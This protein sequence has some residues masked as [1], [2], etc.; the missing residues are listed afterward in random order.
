M[1]GKWWNYINTR[2]FVVKMWFSFAFYSFQA[3]ACFYFF[4][5]FFFFFFMWTIFLLNLLQC[6]FCCFMF[7]C[8][9][10]EACGILAPQ[11][12]IEPS[13]ASPDRETEQGWRAP[14]DTLRLLLKWVFAPP[15]P[16]GCLRMG[17]GPM[18]NVMEIGRQ[19]RTGG[20]M[21]PSCVRIL[22]VLESH[23]A[24]N[25]NGINTFCC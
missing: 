22:T 16:A 12:G 25:P 5:S 20:R 23:T 3:F 2:F 24:D 21:A 11:P 7:W 19:N 8:F 9:G 1:L 4:V 13:W 14:K 6:C 17:P 18:W 15:S 10:C